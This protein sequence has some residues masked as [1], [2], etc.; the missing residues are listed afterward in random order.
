LYLARALVTKDQSIR[1]SSLK[2][3]AQIG[4]LNPGLADDTEQLFDAVARNMV[5]ADLR[6]V[7]DVVH[8][9]LTLL[10]EKSAGGVAQKS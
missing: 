7:V 1:E 9:H 10:R 8:K 6:S 3:I 4:A 5:D 2:E